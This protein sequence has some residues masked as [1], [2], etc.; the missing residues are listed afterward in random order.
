MSIQ[1]AQTA[2]RRRCSRRSLDCQSEDLRHCPPSAGLLQGH[3]SGSQS[4]RRLPKVTSVGVPRQHSKTHKDPPVTRQPKPTNPSGCKLDRQNFPGSPAS[5]LKLLYTPLL[6]TGHR[7]RGNCR[8]KVCV[9]LTEN[10]HTILQV[11]AH[12]NATS[13][14][15]P[16]PAFRSRS[17]SWGSILLTSPYPLRR[18]TSTGSAN[19]RP[20]H[21]GVG[22]N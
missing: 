3:R 11:H 18:S 17:C 5:S 14:D 19:N 1:P 6:Q 8:I 4:P 9:N 22:T 7:I 20:L 15:A 2:M 13:I 16:L 12:A 21:S 10:R